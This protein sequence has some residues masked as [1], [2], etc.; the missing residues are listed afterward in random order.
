[1]NTTLNDQAILRVVR[2]LTLTCG[3]VLLAACSGSGGLGITLGRGHSSGGD[4]GA[5]T[6]NPTVLLI[7]VVLVVI[8]AIVALGRKR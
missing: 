5:T 6:L 3:G 4:G 2:A 7:L 1:M 8:I